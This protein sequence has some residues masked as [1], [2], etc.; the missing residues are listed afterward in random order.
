[1]GPVAEGAGVF[2]DGG[3][4]VV[5]P[6]LCPHQLGPLAASALEDGLVTCAWHGYRFDVRSG[7]CVSGQSCRLNNVPVLSQENGEWVLT[8]Q[9]SGPV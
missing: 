9:H 2:G 7:D 1:M 3:E 4:L 6:A 5:F 8:A